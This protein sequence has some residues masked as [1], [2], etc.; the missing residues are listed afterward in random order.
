MLAG[1]SVIAGA[2]Q[3]MSSDLA[4]HE[5]LI[6]KAY[7]TDSTMSSS[8][9]EIPLAE[10]LR[11]LW[12]DARE[13]DVTASC[14]RMEQV[15]LSFDGEEG[16]TF[17][18]VQMLTSWT[19]EKGAR[20]DIGYQ[21]PDAIRW[22]MRTMPSYSYIEL[23][24]IGQGSMRSKYSAMLYKRLAHEVSRRKWQAGADNSFTLEYTPAELAELVGFPAPASSFFSKLQERVISKL[25]QDFAGVRKFDLAIAYD[26]LP[27]PARGQGKAT[28]RIQLHVKV[29]PDSHHMVHADDR[30]L[31]ANGMRIGRPDIARYRLNSVFWLQ[32][33]KQFRSLSLT[34]D[35]AYWAWRVALDEAL[36]EVP[37]TSGYEERRYRGRRLIEAIDANG[38]EAAAWQFF[39]EEAEIGIDLCHPTRVMAN[40]GE[41]DRNRLKRMSEKKGER[42]S[43]VGTSEKPVANAPVITPSVNPPIT[44]T[45]ETCTHV[46]IEI[47]PA[48]STGDL[49]EFI[50]DPISKV[51]WNG[52][53]KCRLRA[54]FRVPGTLVR[55]HFAFTISPADEDEL[56]SVLRK[57]DRWL[58]GTPVYRLEN[59]DASP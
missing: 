53:R 9:Y 33:A 56:F 26:G 50:H 42:K 39:A 17:R 43:K 57:L 6:S 34:H 38:V 23:A 46:D 45:F 54:Y 41:A 29:H 16:R 31:K 24:A 3:L 59:G 51:A 1:I 37:V 44:P 7:Q 52:T 27:S 32:V 13:A 21:F 5:L 10:C 48:A 11:F 4:L 35:S 25:A 14:R 18:D 22:L 47:D 8:S 49:D 30:S 40:L 58:I 19:A 28:S 36:E 20:V 12:S 2:G 15:R 55:Q